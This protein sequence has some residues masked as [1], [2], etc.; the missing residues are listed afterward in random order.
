MFGELESSEKCCDFGYR[1]QIRAEKV[2]R[3]MHKMRKGKA[4]EPDEIRVEF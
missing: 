2:E 3:A 1:R 4:T